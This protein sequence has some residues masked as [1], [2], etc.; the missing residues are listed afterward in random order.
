MR[1]LF[2]FL[3]LLGCSNLEFV[4]DKYYKNYLKDSTSLILTGDQK[5]LFIHNWLV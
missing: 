5:M 3:L 4:Y 1:F 2:I